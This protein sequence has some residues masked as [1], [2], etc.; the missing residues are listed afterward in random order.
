LSRRGSQRSG[1]PAT[2][3]KD[4]WRDFFEPIVGEVMF[5]PKARDSATDV[6]QILKRTKAKA[7]LKILDLACGTGR[8]SILVRQ[9]RIHGDRARLLQAVLTTGENKRTCRAGKD[10]IRPR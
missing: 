5:T 7:P 2:V 8:H 10:K 6:A 4:W 3:A 9:A 1:K